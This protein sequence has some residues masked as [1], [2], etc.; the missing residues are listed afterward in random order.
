MSTCYSGTNP[1]I[2][3]AGDDT[4]WDDGYRT[5]QFQLDTDMSLVGFTAK[6]Y[7][8]GLTKSWTT[9]QVQT[10]TLNVVFT[11][12]ETD[13]LP[14]GYINGTFKLLDATNKVRTI[15][16][17]LPFLVTTNADC[18]IDNNVS[19]EFGCTDSVLIRLESVFFSYLN[20]T[21]KPSINDVVLTGNKTASQL[22]LV[23]EAVEDGKTYA[24]K[25]GAWVEVAAIS[26][27]AI[28]Q[29]E[30]LIG[31]AFP[32]DDDDVTDDMQSAQIRQMR[33]IFNTILGN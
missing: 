31:Q 23:E 16:S 8:G 5:I 14:V 30:N 6:L 25:D 29:M 10:K 28:Q 19:I 32:A 9:E 22:G 18:P 15:S 4:N 20:L 7:I 21:D 3:V 17:S 27:A 13:L 33:V 11:S 12:A 24:R 1:I 2:L 26:D